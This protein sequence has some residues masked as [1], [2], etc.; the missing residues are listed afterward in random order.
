MSKIISRKEFI[1]GTTKTIV[2][3]SA[4]AAGAS[5]MGVATG[6]LG[7]AGTVNKAADAAPT[8]P[9][10]Y[11]ALDPED[12][13]KRA[14]KFY[15]DGGCGYGA[16]NAMVG[17]LQEAVGAPYTG[18]PT[19]MLYF[20][21]GGGAGWGTLCGALNGAAAAISVI[22]DRTSASAMIGELFGW[23]TTASLPSDISNDYAVRQAFLVN[24]NTNAL[25]Q[26]QPGTPLCH[27]SVSSWCTLSGYKAT[28]PERAER[29]ARLTGDVA[30]KAVEMLNAASQGAFKPAF[31]P[32][33][34]VAECQTCHSTGTINNVQSGVKMS[35]PTCHRKWDHLY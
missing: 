35:C 34:V 25:K 3:V 8:W 9:F 22:L 17:A 18:I 6:Q 31:V 20:G 29:C 15:Y 32:A 28:D 12:I 10:P 13:R 4:C 27:G 19:Q 2:A 23:Y 11:K 7:Q 21:S 30:A 14:H 16:F 1:S 24:R 5:A 26:T 33:K